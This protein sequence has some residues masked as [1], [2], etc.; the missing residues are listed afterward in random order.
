MLDVGNG[1]GGG[2]GGGGGAAFAIGNDAWNDVELELVIEFSELFF[3]F[4]LS[5]EK[6]ERSSLILLLVLLPLEALESPRI[7][8]NFDTRRE[9]RARDSIR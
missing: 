3:N 6:L 7:V 4:E 8:D 1:N 5:I 2:G 9:G